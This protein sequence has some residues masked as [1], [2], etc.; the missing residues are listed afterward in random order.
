M[1]QATMITFTLQKKQYNLCR[2]EVLSCLSGVQP[3]QARTL[4]VDVNGVEFPV[5]Q[6]LSITLGA[7]RADFISHQARAV[8]LRL[9]FTVRRLE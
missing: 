4:V 5:K 7:D 3:E 9:G 2:E 8:F 1:E 6:A